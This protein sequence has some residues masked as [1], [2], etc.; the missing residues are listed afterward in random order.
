[1]ETIQIGGRRAVGFG[2]G[3]SLPTPSSVLAFFLP[4]HP[5]E[6]VAALVKVSDDRAKQLADSF[7]TF[8]PRWLVTDPVAYT[9]FLTDYQLFLAR[10]AIAKSE[11]LKWTLPPDARYTVLSKA[12]RQNYP[13]DGAA[14]SKGDWADLY[15]RINAAQI[16]AGAPPLIDRPL[17]DLA[18]VQSNS[19]A[20]RFY[21]DTAPFDLIAQAVHAEAPKSPEGENLKFWV[22]LAEWIREHQ[23]GITIGAVSMAA[24]AGGVYV[25]PTLKRIYKNR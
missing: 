3:L 6:Q 9:N 19:L 18:N 13:P 17:P 10:Y 1:M 16:A 24:V 7:A 11:A 2:V 23:T 25:A 8:A 14:E 4:D 21:R 5:P 20:M 15:K 22:E 12:F